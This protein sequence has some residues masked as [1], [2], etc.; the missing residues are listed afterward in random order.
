QQVYYWTSRARERFD[1]FLA[2]R[3]AA[4]VVDPVAGNST[5]VSPVEAPACRESDA[6]RDENSGG[7]ESAIADAP[8]DRPSSGASNSAG[9]PA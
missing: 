1:G 6:V 5:A 7:S 8:D 2:R 4:N 9:K 3:R